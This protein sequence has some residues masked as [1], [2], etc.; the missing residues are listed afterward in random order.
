M[1]PQKS[2][3]YHKNV[4]LIF[5]LLAFIFIVPTRSQVLTIQF[6]DLSLQPN[7]ANQSFDLF[8]QNSGAPFAV[9]G[10]L[11]ETQ[12][13]DGFSGPVISGVDILTGTIFQSN[14][15]GAAGGGAITPHI[16]ERSTLTS[17]GTVNIPSGTSKYATITFDTTGISSG[18]F[19]YSPDTD[20]G[21]TLYHTM[22]GDQL[23]TLTGGTLTIVPEPAEYA[24]VAGI[25]CLLLGVWTRRARRSSLRG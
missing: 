12:V 4:A 19:P 10:I 3:I 17:S 16:F 24:A 18:S 11:T 21:P 22:S 6:S 14:N 8:V 9:T 7:T 1:N 5:G 23:L 13:A 25:G 15:N 2:L 20:N